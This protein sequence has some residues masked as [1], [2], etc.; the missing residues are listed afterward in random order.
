M[1]FFFSFLS[2]S[3]LGLKI[4]V[5]GCSVFGRVSR[6]RTVDHNIK[7]ASQNRVSPTADT[8]ER[9]ILNRAVNYAFIVFLIMSRP[10]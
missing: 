2:F 3:F 5:D 8:A 10:A 9:T 1:K 7:F 6:G 4:H